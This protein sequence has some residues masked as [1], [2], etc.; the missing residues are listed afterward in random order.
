MSRKF[1]TLVAIVPLGFFPLTHATAQFSKPSAIP[2]KAL[3]QP[4]VPHQLR[5]PPAATATPPQG[6]S[7]TMQSRTQLAAG[8]GGAGAA[9]FSLGMASTFAIETAAH[10]GSQP[11]G[12]LGTGS[13]QFV[14]GNDLPMW[15]QQ[16]LSV[17]CSA[18]L[19]I[20]NASPQGTVVYVMSNATIVSAQ[21]GP[22]ISANFQYR[23][24]MWTY[25]NASGQVT[26]TGE[27]DYA[28]AVS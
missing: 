17:N 18:T 11:P 12:T 13:V 24:I 8:V 7:L 27:M 26:L 3:Q 4:V 10:N 20:T 2:N 19:T 21:L 16:C 28:A 9:P 15:M 1:L 22:A 14:A 25:Y 5:L 6:I 23:K